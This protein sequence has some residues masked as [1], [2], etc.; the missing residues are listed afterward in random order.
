M[1]T[2][3]HKTSLTLKWIVA[4]LTLINKNSTSLK[5]TSSRTT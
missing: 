1:M 5:T 4:I 3:T 2:G